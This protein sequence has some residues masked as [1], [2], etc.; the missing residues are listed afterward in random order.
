MF[1]VLEERSSQ[2]AIY[3]ELRRAIIMNR[4]KPG[5]RLDVDAIAGQYE[6]SITPVRD[7][8]QM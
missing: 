2:N 4:L 1:P 5:E 3:I 6:T 8:L 7:A